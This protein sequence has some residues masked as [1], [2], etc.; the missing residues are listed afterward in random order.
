[1]NPIEAIFDGHAFHPREP[2]PL[3]PNTCVRLTVEQLPAEKS[4]GGVSFFDIAMGLNLEGPSDWSRN[5]EQYLYGG[6]EPHA[7]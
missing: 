4:Q 2:V 1:M 6:D 5:F 7:E 3:A